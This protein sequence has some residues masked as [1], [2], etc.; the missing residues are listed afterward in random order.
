MSKIVPIKGFNGRFVSDTGKIY[1]TVH[2]Q[3]KGVL[4]PLSFKMDKDGYYYIGLRCKNV[5]KW[6]RV[7]RVVAQAFIPN[8]KNY[9]YVNHKDGNRQNNRV[10]NLEWCDNSYNIRHSY[11]FLHRKGFA[12]NK[13]PC[14]LSNGMKFNSLTDCAKFLQ[15]QLTSVSRAMRHNG[16]IR[17][18]KVLN[19]VKVIPLIKS[20]TTIPKGSSL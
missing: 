12:P 19:G 2:P 8:P 20:V 13:I 5:R 6:L 11:K 16:T 14:M 15:L 3:H 9:P 10:E 18:S 7:S 17:R 1:S 4:V